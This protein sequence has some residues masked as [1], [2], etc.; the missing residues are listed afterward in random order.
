MNNSEKV[1]QQQLV[2]IGSATTATA[3][4]W[5][6]N[7]LLLSKWE[8]N[9]GLLIWPATTRTTKIPKKVQKRW[10]KRMKRKFDTSM[11][12]RESERT[13]FRM[14]WQREKSGIKALYCHKHRSNCLLFLEEEGEAHNG[15]PQNIT[16]SNGHHDILYFFFLS[17][18]ILSSP[19]SSII[20][21]NE[22]I[23]QEGENKESANWQAEEVVQGKKIWKRALCIAAA[24]TQVTVVTRQADYCWSLIIVSSSGSW[25]LRRSFVRRRRRH[26][27]F[28]LRGA[29]LR[30]MAAVV[31]WL[32]LFTMFCSFVCLSA[33]LPCCCCCCRLARVADSLPRFHCLCPPP[34]LLVCE[35]SLLTTAAVPRVFRPDKKREKEKEIVVLFVQSFYFVPCHRR[36]QKSSFFEVVVDVVF[37]N[38]LCRRRHRWSF[39]YF[40]SSSSAGCAV[41]GIHNTYT[42]SFEVSLQLEPAEKMVRLLNM[43]CLF[44]SAGN[45]ATNFVVAADKKWG[46]KALAPTN[47]QF[48]P[49]RHISVKSGSAVQCTDKNSAQ[50]D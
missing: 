16:G 2:F 11:N 13:L 35:S 24:A 18:F 26:G 6:R 9:S 4:H 37:E 5:R 28:D 39:F 38:W 41:V 1:Q 36:H 7:S 46:G 33:C 19:P 34:T 29:C 50:K 25:T 27:H 47:G 10:R 20:M 45:T 44:L 42:Y 17:L 30:R 31:E 14:C 22:W 48:R 3:E 15:R 21:G 23:E 40:S 8:K 49:G 43:F 32:L 12:I